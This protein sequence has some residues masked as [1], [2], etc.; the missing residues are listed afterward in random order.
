MYKGFTKACTCAASVFV[1]MGAW[2]AWKASKEARKLVEQMSAKGEDLCLLLEDMS[3]EG[4]K[5]YLE[6]KAISNE[7]FQAN[8]NG[9]ED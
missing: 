5:L 1:L 8:T 2:N 3:E 4:K 6:M 9:K 7:D